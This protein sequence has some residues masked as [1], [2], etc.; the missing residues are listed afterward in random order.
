LIFVL[1]L[2]FPVKKAKFAG[3]KARTSVSIFILLYMEEKR[4]FL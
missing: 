1:L 2:S 4:P 3:K